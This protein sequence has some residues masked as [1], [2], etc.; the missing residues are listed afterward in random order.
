ME[1]RQL[2]LSFKDKILFFKDFILTNPDKINIIHTD[3]DKW[4]VDQ[5]HKDMD[6]YVMRLVAGELGFGIGRDDVVEAFDEAIN[7]GKKIKLLCGPR[8]LGDSNTNKNS[9][10]ELLLHNKSKPN[11]EL[12]GVNLKH[13]PLYHFTQNGRNICIE[14]PHLPSEALSKDLKIFVLE[15]STLWYHKLQ[16]IFQD[17]L[18]QGITDFHSLKT[19]TLPEIKA[20]EEHDPEFKETY[21]RIINFKNAA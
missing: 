2:K 20:Y 13:T 18:D 15:N 17:L 7:R 10:F 4:L 11:I 1:Y 9:L 8:I 16:F 19:L 6:K 3:I 12:Y 21:Q 14:N 5:L